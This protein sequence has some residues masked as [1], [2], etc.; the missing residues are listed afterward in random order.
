[1]SGKSLPLPDARGKR[2]GA[3][4]TRGAV[5]HGAMRFRT[6]RIVM[7]SHDALKS[8]SFGHADDI[9]PVAFLENVGFHRLADRNVAVF[10][11]FSKHAARRCL[12]L[13]QMTQLCLRQFP[14]FDLPE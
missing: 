9:D 4:R 8:L 7:P 5:K 3:D 12:M 10:F 6:T 13:L 11:K 14:V 2:T 1:M